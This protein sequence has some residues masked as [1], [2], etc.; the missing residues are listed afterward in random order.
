MPGFEYEKLNPQLLEIRLVRLKLT[1]VFTDDIELEIFPISLGNPDHEPYVPLSYTWGTPYHGLLPDWDNFTKTTTVSLNGKSFKIRLN[2]ESALRHIRGVKRNSVPL[3]IDAICIDQ[4]NVLE[5]NSQV[6]LMRQIYAGG[7]YTIIW[8]GPAQEGSKLALYKFE[9]VASARRD[10]F[11]DVLEK[12][13]LAG[14]IAIIEAVGTDSQ[15]WLAIRQV[16]SCCWWSR[17]WVFQE[18]VVSSHS[19]LLCGHD[20]ASINDVME[21]LMLMSDIAA[22]EA[23]NLSHVT[24]SEIVNQ[25]YVLENAM[26]LLGLWRAY[27]VTSPNTPV[28]DLRDALFLIRKL[29]ATDPRDKIYAALGLVKDSSNIVPDYDQPIGQV[30]RSFARQYIEKHRNLDL[31]EECGLSIDDIVSWAPNYCRKIYG[32]TLEKH[33]DR[34]ISIRVY[35]ASRGK[36]AK[37]SFSDDSKTLTLVGCYSDPIMAVGGKWKFT[38]PRDLLDAGYKKQ[39]MISG[40]SPS[41]INATLGPTLAQWKE[42]MVTYG[43]DREPGTQD[44]SYEALTQ[45]R[46]IHADDDLKS[47]FDKTLCADIKWVPDADPMKLARHARI[48]TGENVAFEHINWQ[49]GEVKKEFK[50]A[51][52]ERIFFITKRGYIG[53]APEAAEENDV[54]CVV[55]GA[56]V[57]YVIRPKTNGHYL[58]V[59]E[60]YVHGLMDGQALQGYEEGSFETQEIMLD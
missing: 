13:R 39:G 44:L 40:R 26:S 28:I 25:A 21:T 55:L 48:S 47:A 11:F 4:T 23:D 41:K 24:G 16:L 17:A 59:G 20:G 7:S 14:L 9:E 18:A 43:K 51:M 1:D 29:D 37:F 57:P 49:T 32:H 19:V 3:W 46:Y 34:D 60:C 2:L 10:R 27:G 30:Y 5:R 54:V 6:R 53:L 12:D 8:L 56:E 31:L 22:E 50:L 36:P 38:N 33:S 45:I 35:N 42:L 58:F 15:C 52:K